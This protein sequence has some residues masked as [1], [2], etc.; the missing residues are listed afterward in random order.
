[1][2][3]A[4]LAAKKRESGNLGRWLGGRNLNKINILNDRQ[5]VSWPEFPQHLPAVP[6]GKF[7]QICSTSVTKKYP[8]MGQLVPANPS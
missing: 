3:K 2:A 7:A 6:I 8:R 1:M 5:T 4:A